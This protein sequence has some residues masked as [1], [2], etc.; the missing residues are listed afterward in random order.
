[1]NTS[2]FFENCYNWLEK[3][4]YL[5]IHLVNR[6]KFDPILDKANPISAVSVQKYAK[7]RITTSTIKFG[8]FLYKAKLQLLSHVPEIQAEVEVVKIKNPDFSCWA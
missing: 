3:D 7:E 8:D 1:M 5:I 4:G 6:E 2:N